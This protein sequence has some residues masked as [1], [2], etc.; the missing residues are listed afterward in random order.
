MAD[1]NKADIKLMQSQRLDDTDQG[2]GQMTAYQVIDGEVNNLFPD[3]SRLDRVYGRVSMRKA[4]L[5]V[6]T[7]ARETYYGSHTILTKQVSDPNVSVCFFSS[8]DWFDTRDAAKDRIE[9]YLVKGPKW[10]MSLWNKH[11]KGAS[12]LRYFTGVSW[13]IPEIG[14]VLVLVDELAGV[15]QFA[16]I[17]DVT[18]TEQTFVDVEVNY[19]MQL[20]DITIGSQLDYDFE[21][22]EIGRLWSTTED[23]TLTYD[24]VAADASRY[25]GVTPLAEAASIGDLQVKVEDI[26]T[27]LVPSAQSQTPITDAGVGQAIAPMVQT[28]PDPGFISRVLTY[29]FVP[30]GQL[31][32][33]EGIKPGSFSWSGTVNLVDDSRNNIFNGSTKVGAISYATGVITFGPDMDSGAGT[34]TA[35]YIPACAPTQISQTGGIIIDINNRG[36]SYVSVC[37][38]LPMPGSLK[39]D[40]LASGKWYS[41]WDQGDGQLAYSVDGIID[42]SLGTGAVNYDTGSVSMTL[43]AMPDVGSNVLLFWGKA[44]EYYDLS[45][46]TLPLFYNF[47]TTNQGVA[48]NTFELT[49]IGDGAGPGPSG[50]YCIVDDGNSFLQNG[51]F[52]YEGK[53]PVTWIASTAY[54]TSNHIFPITKN[55]FI[56]ECTIG[57]TSDVAEPI[58]PVTPGATVVDGDVTWECVN[59]AVV[60]GWEPASSP[61]ELGTIKYATG[62]VETYISASQATPVASEIFGIKYNYGDPHLDSFFAPARDGSGRITVYLTNTP[63][64]PGTF[65]IEWH[66]DIVEYDPETRLD[67]TRDPT[68]IF[69]DDSSGNFAEDVNDGTTNWVRGTVDYTTGEVFYHPDRTTVFPTSQY[70]WVTTAWLHPGVEESRVFSNILY[71]PT[72]SYFPPDGTATCTYCT[73]DGANQDEY[74]GTIAPLFKVQPS[75][76]LEIVPGGLRVTDASGKSMIDGTNGKLYT[77]T[78][79]VDNAKVHVG[80]INYAAKTFTLLSDSIDVLS[81]NITHCVGTAS[82]EPAM[83]IVFRTPGSPIVPGSLIVRGTT[84]EGT[85]LQGNSDFSGEITGTGIAGHVD[86]NVGLVTVAFG[87]WVLDDAEAQATDWYSATASDGSGNVWKPYMVKASTMTV[88]CVVSSYLPLDPDL[89]GLDPVRL[90][91]DGKVPIFRDGYII[92]VH[93]STENNLG[94]DPWGENPTTIDHTETLGVTDLDL[95]EVYQ[96]PTDYDIEQGDQTCAILIPDAGNYTVDLETGQVTFL[97]GFTNTQDTEGTA[98]DIN[99][100]GRIEDMCLASDVQITGYIATTN[101]LTHN[102]T[103]NA[104]VSSVLPSADLQSRAYNEFEQDTWTGEWSDNLIGTQPLASYNF[105]DYPITVSNQPSIKERWLLRFTSTTE[106]Q[107]VGENFGVLAEGVSIVTGNSTVGGNPCISILNR[108]FADEYYFV[109]RCDGFGS[110]WANGNCIRFNQDAANYPLW[111]VRTTL[112]APAT[113][114]VDYYTIQI[115][116]DSS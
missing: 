59:L 89:L 74:S 75:K 104:F 2:G 24:T 42:S 76:A 49:W 72:L 65:R 90:P 81:M 35:I 105:V 95:L 70:D 79:G 99:L 98:R 44:A 106:V 68:Y 73:V 77:H 7:G 22:E 115:R 12:L 111:F 36:F 47:F 56:Y 82:I 97:A 107:I 101:A 109:I 19:N 6:Q 4:Y 60:I 113:E 86:F 27:N 78:D 88:N 3:I 94:N 50:E 100:M 21:G 32:I 38:P 63:I 31:Y 18:S 55:G 11:Y 87:I 8:E 28:H 92:V 23:D 110:G 53:N 116:G 14:D 34:G 84:S 66:N 51:D 71:L 10:Q 41:I 46:E 9:A 37:D 48:R 33:G 103:T 114:P 108:Q 61:D 43:G 64:I 54:S 16:R 93:E 39:I 57:G 30:G 80:D 1:I 85:I 102:Y 69:T 5:A 52:N 96:M 83:S 58:W 17:T 67:P 62:E 15:E 20:V 91:L 45:G 26:Q 29:N 40:Y 13:P 25:Y 112:Q